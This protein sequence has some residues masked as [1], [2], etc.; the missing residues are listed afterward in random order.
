MEISVE[1]ILGVIALIFIVLVAKEYLSNN[2]QITPRIKTKL[3]V[4]VLFCIIII[5]NMFMAK[6]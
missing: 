5:F 4:S 1:L 3:R 2:H 6:S